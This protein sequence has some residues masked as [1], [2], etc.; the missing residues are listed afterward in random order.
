MMLTNRLQLVS[1]LSVKLISSSMP[2]NFKLI[3][4]TR[5]TY[6]AHLILFDLIALILFYAEHKLRSS[7]Q[8]NFPQPPLASMLSSNTRIPFSALLLNSHYRI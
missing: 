7:S 4:L 3:A 6:P 8:F 2:H 5:A 1:M